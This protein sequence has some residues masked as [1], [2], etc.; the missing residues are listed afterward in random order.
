LIFPLVKNKN[1][2]TKMRAQKFSR[3][4]F[5]GEALQARS[6]QSL[7]RTYG[8]ASGIGASSTRRIKQ[9]PK[10]PAPQIQRQAKGKAST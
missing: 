9:K 5:N 4:E 8:A 6:V 3:S 7:C 10:E 2:E 1:R